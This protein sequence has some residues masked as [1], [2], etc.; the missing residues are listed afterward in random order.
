MGFSIWNICLL[1]TAVLAIFAVSRLLKSARNKKDPGI[2]HMND[3]WK[4][5]CT[6]RFNEA[7]KAYKLA[8]QHFI[9][10]N[11]RIEHAKS[12]FMQAL[13]YKKFDKFEKATAKF[14]ESMTLC[15]K[16]NDMDSLAHAYAKMGEMLRDQNKYGDAE[17]YY[18]MAAEKWKMLGIKSSQ[19]YAV[20]HLAITQMYLKKYD[21]STQNFELALKLIGTRMNN[22]KMAPAL[23]EAGTFQKKMGKSKEAHHNLL[24]A[25]KLFRKLKNYDKAAEAKK[26]ADGLLLR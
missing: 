23:L 17:E 13:L 16:L 12:V 2:G 4:Y 15:E 5:E 24:E 3:A 11:N 9:S 10:T 20:Y 22:E 6:G 19:G 1:I 25:E 7:L 21:A 18:C 8:E 26:L 14:L